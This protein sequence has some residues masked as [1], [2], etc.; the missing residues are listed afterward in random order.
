MFSFGFSLFINE[1]TTWPLRRDSNRLL[2]QTNI[3][4]QHPSNRIPFFFSCLSSQETGGMR[5][6]LKLIVDTSKLTGNSVVL[7]Q[8]NI[9]INQIVPSFPSTSTNDEDRRRILK[10]SSKDD[11]VSSY[12]PKIITKVVQHL[13][14]SPDASKD[15]FLNSVNPKIVEQ[16]KNLLKEKHNNEIVEVE[17]TESTFMDQIARHE[18][19]IYIGLA[20]AFI[21]FCVVCF[22]ILFY[23][24]KR[25]SKVIDPTT[26]NSRRN[27]VAH[28]VLPNRD[29]QPIRI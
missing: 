2:S 8:P 5:R 4:R 1:S 9:D 17:L 22:S 11:F 25:K 27:L 16:Y 18:N 19:A 3:R 28:E 6:S 23:I 15:E 20:C 7:H 13:L 26:T 21:L 10:D 29:I 12:N 14:D 24:E